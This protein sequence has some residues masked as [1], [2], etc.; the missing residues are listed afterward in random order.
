[1]ASMMEIMD[2]VAKD[3][4]VRSIMGNP[5]GL[6]PDPRR[7]GPDVGDAKFIGYD[8][9]VGALTA[10]FVM[11]AVNTR[12]VRRSH[13]LMGR[14]YGDAFR[15]REVMELPANPKGLRKALSATLMQVGIGLAVVPALRAQM[16]KR[17]PQPGEGPTPEQRERGFF[18]YR[19]VGE[20]DGEPSMRMTARVADK[21]DP[22][23]AST[24]RMLSES[25]LCLAT[26]D[27]P[28]GG[29]VLTP[30]SCMG[31]ALV[32]RLR[33]SGMTFEIEN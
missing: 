23:Y 17:M 28:S 14:P 5:Y 1:M 29:G 12:I 13:A 21:G 32:E 20:V 31:M 2:R 30:A 4:R 9:R 7:R 8:A 22:G 18:V 11:A 6:D 19:L 10:P 27:L 16:Q 15:Y 24:S 33:H 25:A 3:R 26:D